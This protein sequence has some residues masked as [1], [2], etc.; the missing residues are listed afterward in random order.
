[1]SDRIKKMTRGKHDAYFRTNVTDDWVQVS[2]AGTGH[3][4]RN[5][6][7]TGK[8]REEVMAHYEK[9]GYRRVEQ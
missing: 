1:M 7:Y 5:L 6:Q 4:S 2:I 3:G 8:T 9:L